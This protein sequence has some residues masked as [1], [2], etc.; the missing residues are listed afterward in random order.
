MKV[1][2]YQCANN[3]DLINFLGIL[4]LIKI[5]HMPYQLDFLIPKKCIP[6][7]KNHPAISNILSIEDFPQIP[8]HCTYYDHDKLVLKEFEDKYDLIINIWGCKDLSC[9]GDYP[10]SM[11]KIVREAGFVFGGT[12]KDFVGQFYF[13]ADDYQKI[14]K[15]NVLQKI[16]LCEGKTINWNSLQNDKLNDIYIYLRNKSYLLAGNGKEFDIDISK[17]DLRQVKLFFEQKCYGF[18]G[19]SSGMT[20]AIYTKPNHFINKKVIISGIFNEWNYLPYCSARDNAFFFK[21]V[22]NIDDIEII[23]KG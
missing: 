14:N 4:E 8:Q 6:I 9:K 7:L 23:F 18:L 12:R 20:C 15:V 2:F 19:T 5:T 22:Y 13:D 1:L 16:I 10:A 17:F 11:A 3:G 21:D